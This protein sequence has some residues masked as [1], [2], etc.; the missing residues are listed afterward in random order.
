MPEYPAV[1][2]SEAVL[3][4]IV[5][6]VGQLDLPHLEQLSAHLGDLIEQLKSV[7]LPDP[8]PPE[9]VQLAVS[10]GAPLCGS[11]GSGYIEWKWI[12]QGD[13][14]YGPYPYWRF[15]RNGKR[16]SIYLKQLA[17]ELRRVAAHPD[18]LE[19]TD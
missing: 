5:Q 18:Q 16:C 11:R 7:P 12:R 17:Q 19:A 6:Q 14:V 10:D 2:S 15:V 4:R 8:T 1:Q 9:I 13:K 3:T